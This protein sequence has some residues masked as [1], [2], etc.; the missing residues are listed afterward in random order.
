MRDLAASGAVSDAQTR[1]LMEDY[2]KD[3]LLAQFPVSRVTIRQAT[4]RLKFAV[5]DNASTQTALTPEA[6]RGVWAKAMKATILPSMLAGLGKVEAKAIAASIEKGM[7]IAGIRAAI[8]VDD[9][10]FDGRDTALGRQTVDFIMSRVRTL[11]KAAL[12]ALPSE[13]LLANA[14]AEASKKAVPAIR[15]AVKEL[16]GSASSGLSSP[17]VSV[18]ASELREIPDAKIS[19][20]ELSFSMEDIQRM[21]G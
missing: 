19:E 10:V 6:L 3:P 1:R 2:S 12:A 16:L 13:K 14:A 7:T 5:S 11:P 20:I 9:L 21:G 18:A 8:A 15:Q 4:M 17:Q